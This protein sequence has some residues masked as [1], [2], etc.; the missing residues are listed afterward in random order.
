MAAHQDFCRWHA[1]PQ[2]PCSAPTT[3]R[4]TGRLPNFFS[5]CSNATRREVPRVGIDPKA[6]VS[7]SFGGCPAARLWRLSSPPCGWPASCRPCWQLFGSRACAPPV[8]APPV[9][10]LPDDLPS[11]GGVTM[12]NHQ[13][14][15]ILDGHVHE[16]H[17]LARAEQ[18]KAR[19]RIG[20]GGRR[21]DHVDVDPPSPPL[22]SC[23]R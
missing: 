11:S 6:E 4:Q 20:V 7:L 1:R 8:F 12:P 9:F 14:H 5:A 2:P 3:S 13:L 18:Q 17:I 21:H 22:P 10:A 15:G 23:R 19:C 16:D